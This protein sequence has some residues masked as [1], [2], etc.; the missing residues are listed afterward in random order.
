MADS[1]VS[2]PEWGGRRAADALRFVKEIGRRNRTPC[3]LCGHAIDYSL[4]S[5]H[6]QGCTVQ[7]VKSRKHFP[8]LT[9]ARSNWA[10]A[11]AECNFEAGAGENGRGE[12]GATSTEW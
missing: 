1:G 3:V 12:R 4:P 9:W 8:Q 11:H 2:I 5:R 6:P 10:P 7:H